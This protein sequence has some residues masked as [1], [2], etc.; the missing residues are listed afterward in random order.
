MNL[1]MKINLVFGT[2]ILLLS[3]QLSKLPKNDKHSDLVL[4]I[5]SLLNEFEFNGVVSL[6]VDSTDIYLKAFGFS[7]LEHEVPLDTKDQFVIGSIS[8]QITAVLILREVEKGIIILDDTIGQ[9]LP[10][11]KQ[12]WRNEVTIHQLL[13]HT[14][15]ITNINEP[16]EFEPGSQFHYSQFG[17]DLLAQILQKVT[18]NSFK[19]QST[20]LFEQFGLSNTFHPENR[21]YENLVRGYT[22]NHEGNLEFSTNSLR[23]YAAAGSFISNEADLKKWNV[24]LHSSQLV[25]PKTLGLMSKRYASRNHPIFDQVEYGYGLLFKEGEEN[26]QIGA[27]GYAPG[28]VSASYYYPQTKMNLVV[29]ENIAR[30]LSD[31]RT[32]FQVHT[33]LMKLVKSQ[34]PNGRTSDG[35]E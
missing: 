18:G 6:S 8:K 23:N 10:E 30:D 26:V 22:E 4:E 25:K 33:A 24:L 3:C 2:I 17:Y 27:L 7:N 15:G 29:L 19:E 35:V 9:Y 11:L 12:T 31:F 34:T 1:I 13:T 20:F 32:T 5:D 21:Q 16:L 14:H 28:F